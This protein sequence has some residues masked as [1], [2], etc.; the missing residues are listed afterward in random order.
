MHSA[1][2]RVIAE[3]RAAITERH[4]RLVELAS[5]EENRRAMRLDLSE[6]DLR[7][8]PPRHDLALPRAHHA[9]GAC[10]PRE[11]QLVTRA[12]MLGQRPRDVRE[13]DAQSMCRP[14][15]GETGRGRSL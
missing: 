10:R 5:A 8:A 9:E 1:L 3:R 11:L 13:R 12:R 14:A 7:V 6:D 15:D 4:G 2:H